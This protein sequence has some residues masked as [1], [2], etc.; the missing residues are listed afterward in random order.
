MRRAWVLV[1]VA[2]VAGC[3]SARDANPS[4]APP[5]I[6]AYVAYEEAKDG[7]KAAPYAGAIYYIESEPIFSDRHVTGVQVSARAGEAILSFELDAE[8]TE[9]LRSATGGHIGGR[10]VLLFDSEIVGAPIVRSEISMGRGQMS[11]PARTPEQL[12]RITELVH[13][14]WPRD[15]LTAVQAALFEHFLTT[16]TPAYQ[17]DTAGV[18]CLGLLGGLRPY[19]DVVDEPIAAD[20]RKPQD[21]SQEVIARLQVRKQK[22]RPLSYCTVDPDAPMVSV[23]DPATGKGG[24][25]LVID[26]VRL[27]SSDSAIATVEYYEG[28]E[29]SGNWTCSVTR[30]GRR[31]RVAGCDGNWISLDEAY[32]DGHG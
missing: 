19:F 16:L 30:N 21:A 24:V 22:V 20:P 31:W 29:S 10:I 13:A 12:D 2:L 25:M 28:P 3:G 11:I 14:R 32:R 23:R 6:E 27:I 15:E 18:Y 26:G 8:G 7:L 9:R 5:I 4:P 1:I 17:A